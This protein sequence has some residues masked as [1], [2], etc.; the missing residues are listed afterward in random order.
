MSLSG[1][2]ITTYDVGVL[3]PIYASFVPYSED[4][5]RKVDQSNMYQASYADVVEIGKNLSFLNLEGLVMQVKQ[6]AIERNRIKTDLVSI[7]D[8]VVT[9]LTTDGNTYE[10]LFKEFGFDRLRRF[11]EMSSG[12]QRIFSLLISA[13]SVRCIHEKMVSEYDRLGFDMSGIEYVNLLVIDE[14]CYALH[15]RIITDLLSVIGTFGGP[16]V[17]IVFSMHNTDVLDLEDY[18]DSRI[19]LAENIDSTKITDI[20]DFDDIAYW[21]E[22]GMK[23][24]YLEG[25]F[26][27]IPR[28]H[29]YH[30]GYDDP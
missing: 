19:Y 24:A 8:D 1:I 5:R 13:A 10:I 11:G 7:L 17:Q 28:T 23:D 21:R 14:M 27:A 2:V 15:P 30:G 25:R 29:A 12:F 16:S 20:D 4:R 6:T 9:I 26:G 18:R 3:S 22:R